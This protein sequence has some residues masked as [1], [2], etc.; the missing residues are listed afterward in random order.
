MKS[1]KVR[2][3]PDDPTEADGKVKH[4]QYASTDTGDDGFCPRRL[5]KCQRFGLT[6]YDGPFMA[7]V[8]N[9]NEVLGSKLQLVCS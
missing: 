4:F 6:A 8:V 9:S 2:N 7:G 1:R 3:T 5:V